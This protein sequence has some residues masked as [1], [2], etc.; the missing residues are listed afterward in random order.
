MLSRIFAIQEGAKLKNLEQSDLRKKF[1]FIENCFDLVAE[2]LKNLKCP[3]ERDHEAIHLVLNDALSNIVSATKLALY[4]AVADSG[5][6]SR[7]ALEHLALADHTIDQGNYKTLA[8]ETSKGIKRF[9]FEEIRSKT[10]PIIKNL[11]GQLSQYFGH[12]SRERIR[13]GNLDFKKTE[14]YGVSLKKEKVKL[15]LNHLCNLSLYAT[16][17]L[18]SYF[19]HNA[20][21][22]EEFEKQQNRLEVEYEALK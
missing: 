10:D 5:F 14:T 12:S 6:L 16:R 2:N 11:H 13:H 1:D 18:K 17:V 8:Y 21:K 4:G 19:T 15:A 7:L 3:K 22:L 20:I 9:K